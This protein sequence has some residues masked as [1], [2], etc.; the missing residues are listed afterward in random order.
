MPRASLINTFNRLCFWRN[1]QKIIQNGVAEVK[2]S[3]APIKQ[4]LPSNYQN[5]YSFYLNQ[6]GISFRDLISSSENRSALVSLGLTGGVSGDLWANGSAPFSPPRFDRAL[7]IP[8]T[9]STLRIVTKGSGQRNSATSYLSTTGI[10]ESQSSQPI[11]VNADPLDIQQ[12]PMIGG[13]GR[14]GAFSDI[15]GAIRMLA[16]YKACDAKLGGLIFPLAIRT[17]KRFPFVDRQTGE[18]SMLGGWDYFTRGTKAEQINMA[19]KVVDHYR[20]LGN[21]G[22][23]NAKAA[24]RFIKLMEEDREVPRSI[25]WQVGRAFVRKVSSPVVYEYICDKGEFRV[26]HL[27]DLLIANDAGLL[28]NRFIE[29]GEIVLGENERV[30]ADTKKGMEQLSQEQIKVFVDKQIAGMYTLFGENV[31]IPAASSYDLRTFEGRTDYL[32]E[33]YKLNTGSADRIG[34]DVAKEIGKQLGILHGAGGHAGGH[35]WVHQLGEIELDLQKGEEKA[36]LI[37]RTNGDVIASGLTS[38]IKDYTILKMKANQFGDESSGALGGGSTRPGNVGFGLRDLNFVDIL[39]GGELESLQEI[40]DK[41]PKDLGLM[42]GGKRVDTKKLLAYFHLKQVQQAD[43]DLL[44]CVRYRDEVRRA[45]PEYEDLEGTLVQMVQVLGGNE[46]SY[47]AIKSAFAASYNKF[48]KLSMKKNAPKFY[49][50]F[51]TSPDTPALEFS[52]SSKEGRATELI[53]KII[54]E[55]GDYFSNQE[56]VA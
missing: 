49:Q 17:L 11:T 32:C 40:I 52:G 53:A 13:M 20:S 21:E 39:N 30:P 26:G 6:Q 4:L 38:K 18:V 27:F 28:R 10:A 34:T 33:V 37:I 24:Q 54:R 14:D 50:E 22:R 3:R 55:R 12:H 7:V 45:D 42:I 2:N 29:T 16:L 48:Y 25:R 1:K 41:Y 19:S 5:I 51:E 31:V 44:F 15:T 47:A 56:L 9:D 36:K 8:A 43:V 46:A 35:V 23:S